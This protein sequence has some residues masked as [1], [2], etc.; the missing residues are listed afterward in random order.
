MR[1]S[2]GRGDITVGKHANLSS[3]KKHAAIKVLLFPLAVASFL[4]G[5]T[6]LWIGEENN[7]KH[8]KQEKHKKH[9]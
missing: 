8:R 7:E 6:L 3:K 5:W 4:I 1:Q 2:R 9:P